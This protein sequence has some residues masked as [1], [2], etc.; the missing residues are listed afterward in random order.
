MKK[1]FGGIFFS[2]FHL[3]ILL[4]LYNLPIFIPPPVGVNLEIAYFYTIAGD[5]KKM[6]NIQPDDFDRVR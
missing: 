4:T 5:G 3:K 1:R 6:C 2:F